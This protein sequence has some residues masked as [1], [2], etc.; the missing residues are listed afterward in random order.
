MP[1]D[2]T[3]TLATAE[4]LA[5]AVMLFTVR[6]LAVTAALLLLA[7]VTAKYSVESVVVA[8]P[9]L[10]VNDATP[11]LATAPNGAVAVEVLL[12]SSTSASSV[13]VVVAG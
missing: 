2:A 3:P 1:K 10:V 5:V 7:P 11:T 6:E 4:K 9:V 12:R 8:A 13:S